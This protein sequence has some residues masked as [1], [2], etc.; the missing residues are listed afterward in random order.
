MEH[1]LFRTFIVLS[2]IGQSYRGFQTARVPI[3]LHGAYWAVRARNFEALEEE[4][5]P[6][7]FQIPS[8]HKAITCVISG[9]PYPVSEHAYHSF[10]QDLHG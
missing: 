10:C 2:V 8:F 3:G 1:L 9:W 6:L 4:S 7:V 5:K